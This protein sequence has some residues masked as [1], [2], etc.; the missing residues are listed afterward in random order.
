[1]FDKK[2]SKKAIK[3][4]YNDT[5]K[6]YKKL[7]GNKYTYK[8]GNL[9]ENYTRFNVN[10]SKNVKKYLTIRKNE[11]TIMDEIILPKSLNKFLDTKKYIIHFAY[12]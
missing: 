5:M 4:G 8:K 2:L 3:Y 12:V 6:V 1:M 11:K 10:F 9:F 7:D